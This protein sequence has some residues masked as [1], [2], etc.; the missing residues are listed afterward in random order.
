MCRSQSFKYNSR[1][2]SNRRRRRIDRPVGLT[3]PAANVEVGAGSPTSPEFIYIDRPVVL[4]LPA[5]NARNDTHV[6]S[7]ESSP[8]NGTVTRR[9]IRRNSISEEQQGGEEGQGNADSTAE[10]DA[11][12]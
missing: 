9:S 12:E 7:S 4:A 2:Q 8:R 10:N 5:L 11:T 1:R 3:I 6:G